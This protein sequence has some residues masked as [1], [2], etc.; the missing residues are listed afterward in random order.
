MQFI[1][2]FRKIGRI[3]RF[4]LRRS[5]LLLRSSKWNR[6]RYNSYTTQIDQATN[7]SGK[8]HGCLGAKFQSTMAAWK[9]IDSMD[10]LI[11]DYADSMY[12]QSFVESA[13]S[14]RADTT[15]S[16]MQ[17]TARRSAQAPFGRN[18]PHAVI[19]FPVVHID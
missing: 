14:T 1:D 3:P 10:I 11:K 16:L 9:V 7:P 5:L 18:E 6:T 2:Y 13:V 12:E 8:R 17:R 4:G 19:A 15:N